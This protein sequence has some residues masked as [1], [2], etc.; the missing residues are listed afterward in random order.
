MSS[1]YKMWLY[2]VGVGILL[3]TLPY[4][5]LRLVY[6]E[7]KRKGISPRCSSICLRE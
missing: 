1:K 5:C 2:V 6:K 7:R 3:H 4:Y